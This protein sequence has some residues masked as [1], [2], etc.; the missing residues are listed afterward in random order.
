VEVGLIAGGALFIKR[1]SDLS[2]VK[3]P[4]IKRINGIK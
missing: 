4:E 2:L 3:I 1:M